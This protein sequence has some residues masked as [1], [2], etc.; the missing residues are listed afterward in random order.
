MKFIVANRTKE[1]PVQLLR[2]LGY[3]AINKES[4]GEFNLVKQLAKNSFPRFH[5]FLKEVNDK[6]FSVNLHLDQKKPS[7]GKQTAHS[8]EYEQDNPLLEEEAGAIRQLFY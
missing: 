3:I 1:N 5:L 7:Y 2:T 8:G 4:Y 6:S